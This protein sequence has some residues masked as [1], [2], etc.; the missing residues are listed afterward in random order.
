MGSRKVSQL[1]RS[2]SMRRQILALKRA[3]LRIANALKMR[4]YARAPARVA[5]AVRMRSG[6][7]HGRIGEQRAAFA[8]EIAGDEVDELNEPRGERAERPQVLDSERSFQT[9]WLAIANG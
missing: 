8:I 2:S 1:Y 4:S 6:Q 3:T 7:R 5:A 9:A